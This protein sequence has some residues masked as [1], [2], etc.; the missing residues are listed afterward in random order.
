MN[1][2]RL[3]EARANLQSL[4]PVLRDTD[5]LSIDMSCI[6]QSEAPGVSLPSPNGFFGHELCQMS[7]YAGASDKIKSIG[8][9]EV[10]PNKDINDQT[11]HLAAQSI[12]YFIDG[13]SIRT[14]ED[15]QTGNSKKYIVKANH[16]SENMTFYK[17]SLT[18][19]WW[20]ELPIVDSLSGRNHILAC[21]YEDYTRACNS[22]IPDRWWRR[23]R[24]YS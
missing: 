14:H 21:S 18:D 11:S 19:R 2:I 22:E 12:W 5:L 9:F 10:H 23:M 4:E 1:A 17:S 16:P 6:R 15:P 20:I 3:G 7:R 24:R 8:F 13:F